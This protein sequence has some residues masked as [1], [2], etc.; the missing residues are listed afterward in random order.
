MLETASQITWRNLPLCELWRKLYRSKR[1]ERFNLQD[2][3]EYVDSHKNQT[4]QD[5]LPERIIP[6]I[7]ST[8]IYGDEWF[9]TQGLYLIVNLLTYPEL[10]DILPN[11]LVPEK[12]NDHLPNKI[13]LQRLTAPLPSKYLIEL[14]NNC[15]LK[16]IMCGVGELPYDHSKTISLDAFES[17]MRN[18]QTNSDPSKLTFRLNGLGESTILPNFLKYL[19]IVPQKSHVELVTNLTIVDAEIWETLI[20]RDALLLVSCDAV[21]EKFEFIRK[22]ASF[23]IFTNNL[24]LLQTLR[25]KY[26]KGTVYV[27]FTCQKENYEDLLDVINLVAEHDLD[28]LIVNMV[29]LPDNS[30]MLFRSNELIGIFKKASTLASRYNLDL[31]LP[32]HLET[33]QLELT[34]TRPSSAKMCPNP[35]S[36]IYIR[37]NGD[38]TVCNMLNPYIY[39]NINYQAFEQIWNG[40]NAQLFRKTINTDARHP[41]CKNCYYLR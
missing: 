29:K 17:L 28:G 27:I 1:F 8:D 14:T 34:Y 36:E 30:W 25:K 7:E 16:C 21:G 15:N 11:F 19:A 24:K 32:D 10:L 6:E 18:I 13:S 37:Y 9:E 2:L 22:G 3:S 35:W 4:I 40:I 20:R 38:V 41:Y 26:R 12:K 5:L 31:K 23:P 39:G 33:I